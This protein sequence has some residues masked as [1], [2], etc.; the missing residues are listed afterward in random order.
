MQ[1]LWVSACEG[2]AV[3]QHLTK[4]TDQE[5][6]KNAES[7]FNDK[8]RFEDKAHEVNHPG[9]KDSACICMQFM[10]NIS[11][12]KKTQC[13]CLRALS[14]HD[15]DSPSWGFYSCFKLYQLMVFILAMNSTRCLEEL[16]SPLQF[17]LMW[18]RIFQP[19]YSV[20]PSRKPCSHHLLFKHAVYYTKLSIHWWI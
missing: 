2:A 13:I 10:Q 11:A 15:N 19:T 8:S 12:H 4:S 7:G 16:S 18:F 1:V 20:F 6:A 14:Q 5:M 17:P 3:S 9:Y